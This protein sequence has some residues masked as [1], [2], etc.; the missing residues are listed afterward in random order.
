M[1]ELLKSKILFK[2]NLSM[3]I[4]DTNIIVLSVGEWIQ[5]DTAKISNNILQ[6]YKLLLCVTGTM[7]IHC[8]DDQYYIQENDVVLIPPSLPYTAACVGHVKASFLYLFF[9]I[10]SKRN[11][12][13]YNLLMKERLFFIKEY[14]DESMFKQFRRMMTNS[15]LIKDGSYFE[16][17]YLIVKYII[18]FYSHYKNDLM[19]IETMRY[20]KDENTLREVLLYLESNIEESIKVSDLCRYFYVSQSYL[21]KVFIETYKI[22]PQNFI[23]NQKLVRS[24]A[25]LQQKQF[26]IQEIAQKT[27][28]NSIH[29]Y[30]FSFKK[31]YGLSPKRFQ[32]EYFETIK[33]A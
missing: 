13:T 6:S 11:D 20:E 12:L 7:V 23:L 15:N 10:E 19:R 26:G 29:H 22:S 28:F 18:A 14:I 25:L 31:K 5:K 16:L 33:K 9:T 17:K 1:S 21:Y 27:G 32:K 4:E 3:M 30:S 24:L 8:F 2:D